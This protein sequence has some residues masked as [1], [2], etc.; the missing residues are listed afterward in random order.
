MND[1]I[2]PSDRD[3]ALLGRELQAVREDL[4]RHGDQNREIVRVL[5]SLSSAVQ[6]GQSVTTESR[7]LLHERMES[8]LDSVRESEHE[9][10]QMATR[11]EQTLAALQ[12]DMDLVRDREQAFKDLCATVETFRKDVDDLQPVLAAIVDAHDL[13]KD[14]KPIPWNSRLARSIP[15]AF[16]NGL[17][18]AILLAAAALLIW[19]F[20]GFTEAMRRDQDRRQG[21]PLVPQSQKP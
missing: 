3:L 18:V 6:L 8:V 16:H 21:Q 20:P 14:L 12:T 4:Q 15:R 13:G 1:T 10:R 2:R 5:T 11:L 17:A 19:F 9:R 7:R